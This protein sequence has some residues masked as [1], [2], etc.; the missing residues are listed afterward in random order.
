VR[1][2]KLEVHKQQIELN[3]LKHKIF[4]AKRQL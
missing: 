3:E 4:L 1:E 2:K